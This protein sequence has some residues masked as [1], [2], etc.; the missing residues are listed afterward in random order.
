MGARM[1]LSE[2]IAVLNDD[3]REVIEDE[4]EGRGGCRVGDDE[5][6]APG[7][8]AGC[9]RAG[10]RL[11]SEVVRGGWIAVGRGSWLEVR[12]GDD[13]KRDDGRSG[14]ERFSRAF[15]TGAAAPASQLSS[16]SQTRQEDLRSGCR[17]ACSI[18]N[19]SSVN[20][21]REAF[22][23]SFLATF[24]FGRG[25]TSTTLFVPPSLSN[26]KSASFAFAFPFKC[27]L[28]GVLLLADGVRTIWSECRF[29][30]R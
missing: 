12:G 11:G 19:T 27:R 14:S 10:E 17:G 1:R 9:E 8:R 16:P 26:T 20:K 18:A 6:R 2:V 23:L 3:L 25:R 29:E 30:S 24:G 28:L 21:C 5:W 22:L 15:G 4:Y 7:G 13:A